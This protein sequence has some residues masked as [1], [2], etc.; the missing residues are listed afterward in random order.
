M[1][2]FITEECIICFFLFKGE[3]STVTS[4]LSFEVILNYNDEYNTY[5]LLQQDVY[6]ASEYK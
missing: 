1:V 5:N 2:R 4:F 6:V 3:G